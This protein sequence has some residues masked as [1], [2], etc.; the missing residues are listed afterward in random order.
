MSIMWLLIF[1]PILAVVFVI[2]M[3]V[4]AV[5]A[6]H[7]SASCTVLVAYLG[8]GLALLADIVYLLFHAFRSD[9]QL[10]GAIAVSGLLAGA[11]AWAVKSTR[12]TLLERAQVL[13]LEYLNREQLERSAIRSKIYSDGI[14]F[15]LN[16]SIYVDA[17]SA[18]LKTGV[19][20]IIDGKYAMAEPAQ[21]A[22]PNGSTQ[23][24]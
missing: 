15:R 17:L 13:I 1:L 2:S 14:L 4:A 24:E 9:A 3:F 7:S 10:T 22:E 20:K 23:Q 5:F 11:F 8:S 21:T 6:G 18:L 16:K 12:E 19:I